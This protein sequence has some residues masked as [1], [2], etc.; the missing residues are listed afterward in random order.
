MKKGH[1]AYNEINTMGMSQ[2]DL[3]LTVYR[4]AISFLTQARTAY[5]AGNS[6]D[7]RLLSERARRC[8]VHLYTTLDME[9]GED[10][11]IRLG[12]LYAFMIEQ[13]DLA[14]AQQS[15]SRLGNIIRNL[16]TIKEGWED[17]KELESPPRQA[18]IHQSGSSESNSQRETSAKEKRVTISA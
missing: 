18:R 7:G 1:H 13:L 4:G 3:I 12:Q 11:A 15:V 16:E 6:A 17:L 9:K 10:I 2:L 14:M 5:D 8:I